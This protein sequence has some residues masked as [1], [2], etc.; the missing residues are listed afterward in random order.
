MRAHR[1]S[2]A[3][4]ARR[5]GGGAPISRPRLRRGCI[6]RAASFAAAPN[7]RQS[8]QLMDSER[9]RRRL[10]NLKTELRRA[11]EW[12]PIKRRLQIAPNFFLSRARSGPLLQ[13]QFRF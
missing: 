13:L 11:K 8:S 6:A 7:W 9:R 2:F 10:V 1:R 3:S 4:A 12:P 5:Q